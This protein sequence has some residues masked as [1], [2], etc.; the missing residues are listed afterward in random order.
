MISLSIL[1]TDTVMYAPQLVAN[2]GIGSKREMQFE[3]PD[4]PAKKKQKV[5]CEKL[6]DKGGGDPS[7]WAK[8][9]HYDPNDKEQQKRI[10]DSL[11]SW[12]DS[13]KPSDTNRSNRQVMALIKPKPTETQES[14]IFIQKI[15]NKSI[16]TIGH[17]VYVLL[18]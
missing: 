13:I 16:E 8:E 9:S 18:Q 4:G 5:K 15:P 3:S 7:I 2:S 11:R 1:E 10:H 17:R 14:F 12:Y 6:I